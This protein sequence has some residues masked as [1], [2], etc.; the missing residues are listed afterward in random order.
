MDERAG[1]TDQ[2]HPESHILAQ[3]EQR[4]SVSAQSQ[5][6]SAHSML[7]SDLLQPMTAN[8]RRLNLCSSLLRGKSLHKNQITQPLP[9][10]MST[11]C[12]SPRTRPC[13]L[14]ITFVLLSGGVF[15]VQLSVRERAVCL[16]ESNRASKSASDS[17][18]YI[19]L[20]S[21][22][23]LSLSPLVRWE[24]LHRVS[25]RSRLQW[26]QGRRNE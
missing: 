10:L 1:L 5:H 17:T 6:P 2:H 12:N 18:N 24:T 22:I 19:Q 20:L 11:D 15:G 23:S 9:T 8:K 26:M 7:G 3:T 13:N 25:T 14:Q 4:V 21:C 16:P